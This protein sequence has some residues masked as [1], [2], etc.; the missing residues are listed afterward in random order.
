MPLLWW[1]NR[2]PVRIKI[3]ARVAGHVNGQVATG[4]FNN[5]ND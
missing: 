1:A 2:A 4:V 3:I 5:V